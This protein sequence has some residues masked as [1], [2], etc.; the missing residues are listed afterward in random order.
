MSKR[1][2][3]C[4]RASNAGYD[5]AGA[6]ESYVN[7]AIHGEDAGVASTVEGCGGRVVDPE[8]A[9]LVL[10]VGES[11]LLSLAEQPPTAPV[12]PI[13]PGGNVHAVAR[14]K[15]E[16]ALASIF[17][18]NY[19][20][21]SHPILALT[22]DEREIARAIDDAMLITSEPA[23]ISEYGVETETGHAERF[24]ADGVVV[25]TPLGSDGYAGA[26]GGPTIEAEAGLSVVPISPFST[27][28]RTWVVN[29]PIR[30]TVER[31]EGDVLLLA[32]DRETEII[33][34]WE[35]VELTTPDS[36]ELVRVPEIGE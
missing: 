21:V 20:T 7:V 16:S 8:A 14:A 3:F 24:R 19:Q 12:L 6:G 28:A 9:D 33:P 26:A 5:L 4:G 32:D 35:S 27:H 15:Y 23:R 2:A 30:L 34:P 13:T 11:A 25:A 29:P 1:R 36:F 17:E 18:G 31:D 22:I 10:A